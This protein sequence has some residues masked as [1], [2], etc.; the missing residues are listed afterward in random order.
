MGNSDLTVDITLL[1][2]SEKQPHS[3][4]SEFE[5]VDGWKKELRA[6]IGAERMV[7]ANAMMRTFRWSRS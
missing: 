1:K 5:D 4:Q 2:A 3:I 6:V 7:G